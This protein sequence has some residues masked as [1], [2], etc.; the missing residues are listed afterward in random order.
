MAKMSFIDPYEPCFCGSGNKYKFCCKNKPVKLFHNPNESFIYGQRNKKKLSFCLHEDDNCSGGI[1]K[2]HSIQNNKILST[3][4]VNSHVYVV[5]FN[6]QNFGGIDIKPK[7]KKE[8]TV[9]NCFCK[10]HDT[11]IFRDIEL[12]DYNYE[13]KQNYLY[14]YRA[15]SKACFSRMDMLNTQQVLF[16][17]NHIMFEQ[18]IFADSIRGAM[19]DAK[20][21]EK[22]RHILN[23]ALDKQDWNIF[24]TVSITL[25]YEI[26]FAT[27]Y[28]SPI[29][30]DLKGQEI[31]DLW[32]T[33][34][35]MKNIYVTMFPENGK[36]Y[37]LISWL[38]DDADTFKDLKEQFQMLQTKE[39][40]MFRTFNNMVICQSDNFALSPMLVNSWDE[41][42]KKFFLAQLAA[43][44]LSNKNGNISIQI[45]KN[46]ISFP[47]KINLFQELCI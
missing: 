30:Y 11:T 47:S 17:A 2:S 22:T 23:I 13:A 37:I 40:V 43:L 3:L 20:E 18:K 16:E 27:S 31:N 28:V 41:E 34:A 24:E 35:I 6:A 32:N 1:I 29:S 44:F 25:E 36:S 39:E 26:K 42:T 5:D 33:T 19:R 45:E 14:A 10:Y 9:S 12:K 7:G 4:A 15:F 38:R 21:D 8:A 46:L